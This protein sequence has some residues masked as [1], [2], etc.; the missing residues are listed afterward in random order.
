MRAFPPTPPHPPPRPTE[1]TPLFEDGPRITEGTAATAAFSFSAQAPG[2]SGGSG[3]G[4]N[5]STLPRVLGPS[6]SSAAAAVVVA[7]PARAVLLPHAIFAH[8]AHAP[9]EPPVYL[10]DAL[11]GTD[12]ASAARPS[13]QVVSGPLHAHLVPRS[14]RPPAAQDWQQQQQLRGGLGG[15]SATPVAPRFS[16]PR[17]PSMTGGGAQPHGAQAHQQLALGPDLSVWARD[18][19]VPVEEEGEDDDGEEEGDGEEEWE[20]EGGSGDVD[21]S[22]SLAYS[23]DEGGEEEEQEE[24]EDEAAAAAQEAGRDSAAS[25]SAPPMDPAEQLQLAV[26]PMHRR[27]PRGATG[28]DV[29]SVSA[30][31]ASRPSPPI[32]QHP[33]PTQDFP[34]SPASAAV[35]GSPAAAAPSG[36]TRPSVAPDGTVT[37]VMAAPLSTLR[38]MASQRLQLQ[39]P[40]QQQQQQLSSPAAEPL[41]PQNARTLSASLPLAGTAADPLAASSS[42]KRGGGRP[43]AHSMSARR[44]VVPELSTATFAAAT[45]GAAGLHVPSAAALL[46]PA[47]HAAKAAAAL[48]RR[49]HGGHG[50]HRSGSSG[51]GGGGSL[52]SRPSLEEVLA[53]PM[54]DP[55]HNAPGTGGGR[56]A[57]QASELQRGGAC[58][59]ARFTPRPRLRAAGR[60]GRLQAGPRRRRSRRVRARPRGRRTPTGPSR[61]RGQR[62]RRR[63]CNSSRPSAARVKRRRRCPRVAL[64][65]RCRRARSCARAPRARLRRRL[66]CRRCGAVAHVVCRGGRRCCANAPA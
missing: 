35:V 11:R 47:L 54:A 65:G 60:P 2:A 6:S 58:P 41:S 37:T 50:H 51:G 36:M 27:R 17:R 48:N 30:G 1:Q 13:L 14:L 49:H 38:R 8:R 16:W 12:A 62:G 9:V 44:L 4:D 42:S 31:S 18:W 57:I 39:Q 29:A 26:S 7:S 64:R 61:R 24:Q 22:G 46:S 34:F 40:Q 3:A 56:V 43:M 66:R 25:G 21:V 52:H 63:R 23:D 5:S 45:S 32:I 10:S 33:L 53:R 55:Y 15:A 20:G 28:T 59:G 19:S